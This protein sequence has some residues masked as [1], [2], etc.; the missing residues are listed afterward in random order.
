M[1]G[2]TPVAG[3][4]VRRRAPRIETHVDDWLRY[5]YGMLLEV[6][7]REIVPDLLAGRAVSLT[8][9][10]VANQ[11]LKFDCH[12]SFKDRNWPAQPAGTHKQ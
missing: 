3:R 10:A 8:V 9:H 7:Q 5:T 11:P 6:W 2:S 12:Q 1:A 4:P